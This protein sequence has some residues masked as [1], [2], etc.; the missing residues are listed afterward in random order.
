M[1]LFIIKTLIGLIVV[2][3]K[4]PVLYRHF[5]FTGFLTS[6]LYICVQIMPTHK[7]AYIC[8]R[9]QETITEAVY[10]VTV[11]QNNDLRKDFITE[12]FNR[13]QIPF[14]FMLDG[15][16]SDINEE[17]L[18]KF[19]SPAIVQAGASARESCSYKHLLIYEELLRTSHRGALIFEDD[20]FLA[21]DFNKIFNQTINEAFS[22]NDIDTQRL[23]ISYEN[24]LLEFI[25]HS[26]VQPGIRLYK[27][28]KT[29]CAGAYYIT[30]EVAKKILD[31][32]VIS[33]LDFA[34]DWQ[35]TIMADKGLIDVYWCEP[36]IAEQGSHN[37]KIP[38]LLDNKKSGVFRQLNWALQ[39]IYK[40]YI[41][42]AIK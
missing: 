22:R 21:E 13:H 41:R 40:Q 29:R 33:K 1:D 6:C 8:K 36:A 14:K 5:L 3:Q 16:R 31:F 17:I 34:I 2:C 26:K 4:L 27:S 42:R 11:R 18:S 12:Q 28:D 24:S 30:R 19:F 9:M 7:F 32:S 10:V 38:S 15:D 39:R 25:P 35:H 23:F 37:G 20:I